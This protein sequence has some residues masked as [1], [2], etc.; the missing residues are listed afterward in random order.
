[1]I[2]VPNY[3][4]QCCI[5]LGVSPRGVGLF[6]TPFGRCCTPRLAACTYYPSRK[7]A[8]VQYPKTKIELPI[9]EQVA[10][11]FMK[12][13]ITESMIIPYYSSSTPPSIIGSVLA[14]FISLPSSLI[15]KISE[16]RNVLSRGLRWLEVG[17]KYEKF[18][19]AKLYFT[20]K[21]SVK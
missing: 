4:A 18:K 1:L 12:L 13:Y 21:P 7:I 10:L 2:P 15:S 6:G 11:F 19:P 20:P 3:P 14:S 16:K 5:Y 9:A 8:S 17:T